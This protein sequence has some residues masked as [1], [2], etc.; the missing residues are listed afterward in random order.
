MRPPSSFETL[1]I[2]GEVLALILRDAVLRT[3]PQDEGGPRTTLAPQGEGGSAAP[4]LF[5]KA[6]A[7]GYG[8]AKR[9]AK[10]SSSLPGLTRQSIHLRKMVL[11]AKKMDARVKPAHDGLVNL[12]PQK[13]PGRRIDR[14]RLSPSR[15]AVAQARRAGAGDRGA[16]AARQRSLSLRAAPHCDGCRR[17]GDDDGA[18]G[19]V[20]RC[21]RRSRAVPA[22]AS[23]LSRSA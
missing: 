2:N 20:A 21:G 18:A 13:K 17:G 10:F 9:G 1:A 14:D 16:R 11:L 4:Q 19:A 12:A 22:R 23:S 5:D 8:P 6:D 7:S 15:A 3:A